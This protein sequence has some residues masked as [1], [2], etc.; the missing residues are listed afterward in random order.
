MIFGKNPNKD[1]RQ[2]ASITGGKINTYDVNPGAIGGVSIYK[3]KNGARAIQHNGDTY[4]ERSP[5]EFYKSTGNGRLTIADY[6]PNPAPPPPSSGG[7]GGGGGGGGSSSSYQGYGM[8][9]PSYGNTGNAGLDA[10]TMALM[11]MVKSLTETLAESK[12]IN[13]SEISK[14]AGSGLAGTI[15]SNTYVPSSEKKK[16]S[17]LTPVAV[18]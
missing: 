12:T 6:N 2:Q 18:G 3:G 10:S 16:K 17:Y 7:G 11:D 15:L 4:V 13:K 9:A 5:G 1:Y 8:L 14:P